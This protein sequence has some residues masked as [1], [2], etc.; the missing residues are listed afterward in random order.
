MLFVS[1]TRY[2]LSYQWFN[3]GKTFRVILLAT[4]DLFVLQI[5]ENVKYAHKTNDWFDRRSLTHIT[6]AHKHMHIH[7]YTHVLTFDNN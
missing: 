7:I 5:D 4:L 3:N 2:D 1:I 6:H